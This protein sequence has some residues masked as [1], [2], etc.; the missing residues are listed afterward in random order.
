MAKNSK[1]GKTSKETEKFLKEEEATKKAQAEREQEMRDEEAKKV[2]ET[3]KA[4]ENKAD[5]IKQPEVLPKTKL[6]K[7]WKEHV[8]AYKKLNPVKYASKKAAGHFDE[9]PSTFTGLNQLRINE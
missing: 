9:I 4:E 6:E 5:P 1:S 2:E 3:K 8:E 7:A